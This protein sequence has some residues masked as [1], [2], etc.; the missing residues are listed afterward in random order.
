MFANN[1]LVI[2][3]YK[4]KVAYIQ[5]SKSWWKAVDIWVNDKLW[6][7]MLKRV[8]K[9]ESFEI[10]R[11]HNSYLT[12]TPEWLFEPNQQLQQKSKIFFRFSWFKVALLENKR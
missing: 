10:S 12:T 7:L 4:G 11:W 5:P 8:N 2:T 3:I 9:S 6:I 1:I